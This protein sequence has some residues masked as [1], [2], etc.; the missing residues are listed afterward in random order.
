MKKIYLSILMTLCPL[1]PGMA[2]QLSQHGR[3]TVCLSGLRTSAAQTPMPFL[4][5]GKEWYYR[6]VY[7]PR[8]ADENYYRKISGDTLVGDVSYWK[9]V[10]WQGKFVDGLHEEGHKVSSVSAGGLFDFNLQLNDTLKDDYSGM[11]IVVS[12]SDTILVDGQRY[13]RLGIAPIDSYYEDSRFASPREYWVEGIGSSY[14][15]YPIWGMFIIG[16]HNELDSCRVDG[17]LLFTRNDF[18]RVP[19]SQR[20][21]VLGDYRIYPANTPYLINYATRTYAAVG[22]LEIGGR[23][24]QKIYNCTKSRC[25]GLDPGPR[26]SYLFAMRREGGRVLADADSYRAA[27]AQASNVYPMND[28]GEYIL[29]DYDAHVGD[30]YLG[31]QYTVV[32][33]GD[34]TLSDGQS[35]RMLVLS[36]GH[37]LIEGVGCVNVQGTPFDYLCHDNAPN[38]FFDFSLLENYYDAEGHRIYVNTREKAYEAIV[39]GVQTVATSDRLASDDRVYD[40][41][42]RRMDVRHLPKGIY[43]QHGKKFVV[44]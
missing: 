36:S 32:E 31:T 4:Q 12:T 8:G 27:F 2:Q 10:N 33:E 13:F 24:Y 23:T 16:P 41:Q 18:L 6:S 38:T 40:L 42:G 39:A 17:K 22:E 35:R 15:L 29:Y 11:S 30:A 5:E 14:G 9:L 34:T 26:Y 19:Q 25:A 44:K 3:E 21:W 20:Q 28:E 7:G 43:I 37:R 1:L